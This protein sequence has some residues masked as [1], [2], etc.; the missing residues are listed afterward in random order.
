MA[1]STRLIRRRIKSVTNTRKITKAME[2]VAASKMK[3][4]VQQTLS[5]R[6]YANTARMIVDEIMHL[7]DPETHVLL[8]GQHDE[9][10]T[11][12]RQLHTL[13]IICSS[14]RGLC[15]GFNTNNL[16]RTLAFLK[17]RADDAIQIVTV[18]KKA[19]SAVKRAGYNV[20][21]TFDAISNAPSYERT[22]P[23]GSLAVRDFVEGTTD[24]VFIAYMDYQSALNQIPTVEQI[25]PLIPEQDMQRVLKRTGASDGTDTV[26]EP[27]PDAVLNRLLPGLVE[28]RIYQALLESSAS[29]H[30][31]RMMA[32]RSATDNATSMIN[33]LTLTYNQARQASITQE[34]SEI[35]A[36]KAALE[37]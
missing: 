22:R 7:V 17:E 21:A 20:I 26:F 10:G 25:L 4:S 33:D 29:E 35:S 28:T 18:G 12:H 3:K 36:G 15:G 8:T 14:D 11:R 32:M 34:I 27:N 13:V 19:N 5:S 16:K 31:S 23:I 1:V 9:R 2:L 30:S 24:R 37:Q 6:D